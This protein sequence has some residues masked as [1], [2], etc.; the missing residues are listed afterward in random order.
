MEPKEFKALVGKAL[1]ARGLS[2]LG[3]FWYLQSEEVT[4]TFYLQRSSYSKLFYLRINVLFA[5]VPE[6]PFVLNKQLYN[7]GGLIWYDPVHEQARWLD[8]ENDLSD[9]ERVRQMEQVLDE[10]IMPKSLK[11]L[12]RA[13]VLELEKEGKVRFVSDYARE[14]VF[15][16]D[17]PS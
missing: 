17:T 7:Q 12:T 14:M 2:K 1:K 11:L 16:K 4:I 10:Y 6:K 5:N 8:L 9:E 3:V 15:G 13:G